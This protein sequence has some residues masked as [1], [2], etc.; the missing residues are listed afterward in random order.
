MALA[1]QETMGNFEAAAP[2][3]RRAFC[4]F[5]RCFGPNDELTLSTYEFMKGIE[6]NI[7][8]GLDKVAYD[9]LPNIIYQL[10]R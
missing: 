3:I 5:W 8:S 6:T 2:W 7:D 9:E 10:E 4:V 1:Y